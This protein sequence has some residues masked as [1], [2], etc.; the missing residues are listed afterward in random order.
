VSTG[1]TDSAD[2]WDGV[3]A[4]ELARRWG[5]PRVHLY[6]RVG[7]TNDV[8]RELAESGAAHGTAVL[9]EEQVAGRGR[10][11]RGW[12]SPPGLGLW[13]SL[14]VRG[15]QRE[16]I[17]MLPLLVG[18]ATAEA[19]DR[20]AAPG[21]VR[22][23]W[24]NDLLLGD[25]K[26][27]GI[28]CEAVWESAAPGFVIAGIGI[29]LLQQ[30]EDFHPEIRATAT[31]L[32]QAAGQ[33][34]RRVDVAGEVVTGVLAAVS[35]PVREFDPGRLAELA[36]RDALRGREVIVTAGTQPVAGTALGI[37]P[38]GALLVRSAPGALRRIRSGSVRL[39]SSESG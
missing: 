19:L 36:S 33:P 7:S 32:A 27:C 30:P 22:I 11:G 21:A 3:A 39:L 1:D 26:L 12:Q 2:Q 5:V 6:Q 13:L 17:A 38:D 16:E 4:E 29:N 34:P 20:F 9:A 37:A 25:R 18:L 8:A 15:W 35:V 28:L 10:G 24:P 31:S 14:V 23:K